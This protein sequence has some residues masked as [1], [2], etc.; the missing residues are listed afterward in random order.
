MNPTASERGIGD[1]AQLVARDG[2]GD[3]AVDLGDEDASGSGRAGNRRKLAQGLGVVRGRGT[4]EVGVGGN[5]VVWTP[6]VVGVMAADAT[7]RLRIP[8]VP[9]LSAQL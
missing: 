9:R 1:G 8:E 2:G 4:D 7:E 6:G 5:T 3:A